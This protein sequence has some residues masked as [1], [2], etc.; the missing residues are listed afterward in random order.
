MAKGS[1]AL[2]RLW[3]NGKAVAADDATL[4]FDRAAQAWSVRARLPVHSP[5]RQRFGLSMQLRDG[6][7]VHGQAR[8]VDAD[9]EEVVF[10]GDEWFEG[11]L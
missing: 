9:G 10:E 8:L 1:E 11:T 4:E 5:F 3:V 6:R 2:A 7:T